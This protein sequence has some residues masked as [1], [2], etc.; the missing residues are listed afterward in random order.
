MTALVTMEGSAVPRLRRGHKFRYDPVREAWVL[1]GPER[2][3]LPDEHAVE[4]LKL[5]DGVRSLDEIVADLA[6][7]YAAPAEAIAADVE[8][9][10]SDLAA[11][12]AL[13]L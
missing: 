7:R 11:R 3:F 9:M 8:I 4:I 2:L 6:A 1:L 13:V 5:V 12:G 10:L